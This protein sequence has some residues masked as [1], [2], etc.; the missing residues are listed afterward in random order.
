MST[1]SSTTGVTATGTNLTPITSTEEATATST[2]LAD[3]TVLRQT[4]RRLSDV[5]VQLSRTSSTLTTSVQ[6][7]EEEPTEENAEAVMQAVT[8]AQQAL[9][10]TAAALDLP[11]PG[12]EVPEEAAPPPGTANAAQSARQTLPEGAVAGAPLHGAGLGRP[13]VVGVGLGLGLA[14]AGGTGLQS[15]SQALLVQ[16][17]TA[18]ARLV[19]SLGLAGAE[20]AQAAPAAPEPAPVEELPPAATGMAGVLSAQR[21]ALEEQAA[22]AA[23]AETAMAAALP[24]TA[25]LAL[26]G[27]PGSS[28]PPASPFVNNPL[29][30]AGLGKL[31]MTGNQAGVPSSAMTYAMAAM[32]A[33]SA[34]GTRAAEPAHKGRDK[35]ERGGDKLRDGR[36]ADAAESRAPAGASRGRSGTGGGGGGEAA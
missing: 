5:Q 6:A 23:A 34:L 10:D 29:A 20:R 17:W 19:T 12:T 3:A 18:L 1:I 32:A 35:A 22:V 14:L 11:P 2:L 36:A 9:V 30:G 13:G 31:S 25:A 24:A 28:L 21:E 15:A 16:A 4:S 27:R 26:A 8:A 7:L 33:M